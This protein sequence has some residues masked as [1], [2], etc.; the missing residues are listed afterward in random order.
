VAGSPPGG[1]DFSSL[2]LRYVADASPSDA[3]GLRYVFR[4]RPT[5][6]PE[7]R[8]TGS[9]AAQEASD[10]F[11][12]WLDLSPSTFTVNLNPNEPF[13][14]ID[15]DLGQTD[16][17]RTLLEADFAMKKLVARLIHPDTPQGAQF[18]QQLQAGPDSNICMSLRQW[19]VPAP[20]TVREVGNQLYILDAPLQ[21][22]MESDY[23]QL[24]SLP[25][26]L[27]SLP[28]LAGSPVSSQACSPQN[29]AVAQHNEQVFRTSILP[30]VQQ[31]VNQAPEFAVLRRVYLSRVAAE[32][33]RQ[34]S[35]TERTRYANLIDSGIIGPWESRQPWNPKDVFN[36]YLS[37]YTNGEFKVTHQTQ[38][39]NVIEAQTYVY[40][41][42]D[43][44]NIPLVNVTGS[45]FDKAWPHL[46]TRVGRALVQSVTDPDRKA[47]WLGG[48][49]VRKA[50]LSAGGNIANPAP[51]ALTLVLIGAGVGTL[52]VI[53]VAAMLVTQR[54][55][56]VVR[57]AACGQQNRM[58]PSADGRL[59]HCG[60]CGGQLT[61]SKGFRR[62]LRR[63]G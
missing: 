55:P 50:G 63:S 9:S 52:A 27:P 43:F 24:P 37:S 33:Y 48:T 23:L 20:A 39:G 35:I 30:Q 56:N 47:I 49:T 12:V 19:I 8:G 4:A 26:P 10:A 61:A 11:F 21:V 15:P 28:S 62:L 36:Q 18:W 40:G 38:L 58:R 14:I 13:Q 42:V 53:A 6:A 46:S 60:K 54:G 32:W 25:V 3:R 5:T 29:Q 7:D 41:G 57:C 2:E 45:N 22:K 44:T 59:P 34:R 1:I 51:S 31:A 17:G 16:V